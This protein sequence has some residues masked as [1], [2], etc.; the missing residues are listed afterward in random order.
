MSS[1]MTAILIEEG[2]HHLDLMFSH[3]DD[4]PSVIAAR[5]FE[6]EQ[7]KKWIEQHA[8]EPVAMSWGD[9]L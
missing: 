6:L 3:K 7:V 1:S 2:A 9:L 8:K 4:P 5:K